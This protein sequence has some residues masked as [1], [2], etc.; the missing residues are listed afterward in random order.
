M[1][2]REKFNDETA[3]KLAEELKAQDSAGYC[4]ACGGTDNEHESDCSLK[5]ALGDLAKQVSTMPK[6]DPLEVLRKDMR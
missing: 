4:I 5:L 3:A 1:D 6:K 2:W